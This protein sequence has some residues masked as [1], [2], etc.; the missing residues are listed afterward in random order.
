MALRFPK[1]TRAGAKAVVWAVLV[2]M[3]RYTLRDWKPLCGV[4]GY[5]VLSRNSYLSLH[6]VHGAWAVASIC[7]Q[8][9]IYSTAAVVLNSR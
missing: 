2:Y 5:D 3:I 6:A 1:T 8:N 4:M 9:K 7:V